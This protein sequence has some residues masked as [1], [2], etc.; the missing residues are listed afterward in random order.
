LP[1][2]HKDQENFIHA[3]EIVSEIES[4]FEQQSDIAIRVLDSRK[5]SRWY[6]RV[7]YNI[8]Y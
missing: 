3:R 4:I 7:A 8:S 2:S 1:E 6:N 5:A